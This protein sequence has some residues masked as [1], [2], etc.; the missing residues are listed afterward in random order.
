MPNIETAP[1]CNVLY[2][3]RTIEQELNVKETKSPI[4]NQSCAVYGF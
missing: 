3:L 1:T 4:V 2:T